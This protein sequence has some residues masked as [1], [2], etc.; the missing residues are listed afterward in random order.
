M[1]LCLRLYDARWQRP[2]YVNAPSHSS[3]WTYICTLAAAHVVNCSESDGRARAVTSTASVPPATFT[4]KQLATVGLRLRYD[5]EVEKFKRGQKR[6]QAKK[7][8]MAALMKHLHDSAIII[9]RMLFGGIQ[10]MCNVQ[11]SHNPLLVQRG[12]GGA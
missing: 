2:G 6:R 7:Q 12:N 1:V 8:R 9:K 5:P 10:T 11:A 3:L 4:A